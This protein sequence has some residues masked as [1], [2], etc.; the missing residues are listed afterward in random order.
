MPAYHDG[1]RI[2]DNLHRLAQALDATGITWEAIVVIDG[3]GETDRHA[4]SCASE[5]IRIKSY[6]HNQGKGFA[7][8]Y[9]IAFAKGELITL[10]NSDMEIGPEEIGRMASLLQLYD[11]DIV[12]G[13]KRHPLSCVS[14]PL[15]RRFQSWCYQCLVRVLFRVKV[16]DTQTGLKMMRAEVAQ[17]VLRVALVKRF[18]FD[19]E[20]LAVASHFGYRRIIEAP[21]VIDYKF[22]SSTN[23]RAA[24]LVLWDTAAIFYRLHL[25]GTYGPSGGATGATIS[26]LSGD[27]AT[28][29]VEQL[30]EPPALDEKAGALRDTAK[31]A[32]I[33][34]AAGLVTGLS[35]FAFNVVVARIGGPNRYGAIGTLLSLLTVL[36]FLAIA[37]QFAVARIS[38]VT[39]TPNGVILARTLRS[40]APWLAMVVPVAALVP[41]ASQFLHVGSDAPAALAVATLVATIVAAV[42]TGILLGRRRFKLVAIL[43]IANALARLLMGALLPSILDPA[44]AALVASLLATSAQGVVAVILVL[45]SSSQDVSPATE[46]TA[47]TRESR[48]LRSETLAGAAGSMALWAVWS[49]PLFAARHA[50]SGVDSGQF[51]AAQVVASSILFATAPVTAAFFPGL[52]R[53]HEGSAVAAGIAAIVVLALAATAGLVAFGP[54]LMAHLYGAQFLPSR[55]LLMALGLSATVVA[56]ATFLLWAARAIQ[57]RR[58]QI[59]VIALAALV[60]E[61]PLSALLHPTSW[62]LALAPAAALSL[63]A[64]AVICYAFTTQVVLRVAKA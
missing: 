10:I 57:K 44:S 7:L 25:R 19:L 62:A 12:V 28:D 27:G 14:Y 6:P 22:S 40:Y 9:G 32:G 20:L 53:R 3:D 45:R 56:A 18:A 17:R 59:T 39:V 64:T 63:T 21:V 30:A 42:P 35:N 13:S 1:A 51:V 26:I 37:A 41:L 24:F 5:R 61:I 34:T 8:R 16:R 47:F 58:A 43:L 4:Q 11:A 29:T 36:S 2:V 55:E 52:A 50:L 31:A 60:I 33:L 23:L 49:V 15:F 54:F 48:G 46:Q 38:A